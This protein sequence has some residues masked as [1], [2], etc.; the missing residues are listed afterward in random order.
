MDQDVQEVK[1]IR[2][3]SILLL[4][5]QVSVVTNA[6]C[7]CHQERA[8]QRNSSAVNTSLRREKMMKQSSTSTKY[9]LD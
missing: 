5:T 2:T 7:L 8:L 3:H 1:C 4:G 9:Y 6:G